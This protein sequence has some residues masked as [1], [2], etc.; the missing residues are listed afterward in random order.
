MSSSSFKLSPFLAFLVTT[1][2][3]GALFFIFGHDNSPTVV[4]QEEKSIPQQITDWVILFL[5]VAVAL[6]IVASRQFRSL[7][8]FKTIRNTDTVTIRNINGTTQTIDDQ[9]VITNTIPLE[10]SQDSPLPE[11]RIGDGALKVTLGE[12]KFYKRT[13]S[14]GYGNSIIQEDTC[15]TIILTPS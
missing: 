14:S 12:N 3:V 5:L 7:L 2:V 10:D 8:G 6:Q 4:H 1:L 15:I 11:I 9:G 13:L